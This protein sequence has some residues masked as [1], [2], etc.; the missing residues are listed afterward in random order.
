MFSPLSAFTPSSDAAPME[1]FAVVTRERVRETGVAETPRAMAGLAGDRAAACVV[2]VGYAIAVP[3]V[4][5][6]WNM[7]P[8]DR[9]AL[10]T[11][12]MLFSVIGSPK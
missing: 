2:E 12:E 3:G 6:P 8:G 4:R 9:A 11:S 5:A 1:A 10:E 7:L